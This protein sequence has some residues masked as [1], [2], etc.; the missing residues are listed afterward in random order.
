M[1]K[2][3]AVAVMADVW[4]V[5]VAGPVGER[6]MLSV[7]GDPGDE[8]ALQSRGPEASQRQPNPAPGLRPVPVDPAPNVRFA[9]DEKAVAEL[10]AKLDKVTI[11]V[12]KNEV[13]YDVPEAKEI[14]K[15]SVEAETVG[16]IT[17]W[18][19]RKIRCEPAST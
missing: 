9:A 16:G 15:C 7:R 8:R 14:D 12:Q 10:T 4:R 13:D 5:R 18:V 3:S 19:V 11:A 17:G 6:V 1:R 2:P